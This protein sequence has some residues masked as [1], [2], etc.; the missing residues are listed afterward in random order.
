MGCTNPPLLVF[1]SH[2]DLNDCWFGWASSIQVWHFDHF[3]DF[4]LQTIF[5]SWVVEEC[6]DIYLGQGTEQV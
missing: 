6:D 2:S 1:L 4:K 3:Y 5:I